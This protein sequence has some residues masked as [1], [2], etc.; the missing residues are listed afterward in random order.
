M[1]S[2]VSNNVWHA[3]CLRI[4][5]FCM[6]YL[7]K[8]P[9]NRII[10]Y[11]FAFPWRRE[12]VHLLRTLIL[13]NVLKSQVIQERTEELKKQEEQKKKNPS[14][15]EHEDTNEFGNTLQVYCVV[16]QRAT[17]QAES[18]VDNLFIPNFYE[19]WRFVPAVTRAWN[20][21]IDSN[22]RNKPAFSTVLYRKLSIHG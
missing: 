19:I 14:V 12:L 11:M 20:W 16:V 2:C 13:Y 3:Q 1:F 18:R 9:W 8:W 7:L 4:I 22:S 15:P 10:I 5:P 17:W 21:K 6:C